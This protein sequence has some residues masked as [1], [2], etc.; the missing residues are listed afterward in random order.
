MGRHLPPK[1]EELLLVV[2]CWIRS[3][4]IEL[5]QVQNDRSFCF[6]ASLTAQSNTSNHDER[7]AHWLVAAM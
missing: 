5:V 3:Q 1:R 6:W 4:R 2:T 7:S